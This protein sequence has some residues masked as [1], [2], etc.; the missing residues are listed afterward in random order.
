M[1]DIT[2]CID[3]K[4]QNT[5]QCQSRFFVKDQLPVDNLWIRWRYC[6]FLVLEPITC[7]RIKSVSLFLKSLQPITCKFLK[8]PCNTWRITRVDKRRVRIHMNKPQIAGCA[9]VGSYWFFNWC[10]DVP[11]ARNSWDNLIALSIRTLG[12]G[13]AMELNTRL[14]HCFHYQNIQRKRPHSTLSPLYCHCF[15]SWLVSRR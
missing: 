11:T 14:L 12:S 4:Y 2:L 1:T 7:N 10:G 9:L 3:V 6:N 15:L 8:Q 13:E 5:G